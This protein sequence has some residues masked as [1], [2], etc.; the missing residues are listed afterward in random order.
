[1]FV[2]TGAGAIDIASSDHSVV[3]SKVLF[4]ICKN[5]S[6]S[7]STSMLSIL[8]ELILVLLLWFSPHIFHLLSDSNFA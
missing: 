1:V 6:R 3:L 2:I 5:P 8:L 7:D 4:V